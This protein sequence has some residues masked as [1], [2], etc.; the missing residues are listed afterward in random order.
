MVEKVL[1][2]IVF[3]VNELK[4]NT[5]LSKI[6]TKKLQKKGYS[7]SEI[8]AAFSWVADKVESN[9]ELKDNFISKGIRVFH[10]LEMQVFSEDA[11]GE[12][13]QLQS[14]GILNSS[15]I[16]NIIESAMVNQFGKV[17]KEKLMELVSKELFKSEV[18]HNFKINLEGNER[19]N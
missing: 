15:Q 7:D 14:L 8:S 2:I 13:V 4:G 12:L 17:N 19:I 5:D 1:K 6:D 11:I 18:P 10:D 3:L 16:E 9:T